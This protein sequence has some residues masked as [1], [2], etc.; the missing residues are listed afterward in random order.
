MLKYIERNYHNDTITFENENGDLISVD[1]CSVEDNSN[2]MKG[3]FSYNNKD[4]RIQITLTP[5]A[6][7][8]FHSIITQVVQVKQIGID[9]D[10]FRTYYQAFSNN[11]IYCK[12]EFRNQIDWYTTDHNGGEPECLIVGVEFEIV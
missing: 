2:G 8:T 12:V 10:C 7:I 5:N 1:L 4:Y 9:S 6:A 3:Y 11:R